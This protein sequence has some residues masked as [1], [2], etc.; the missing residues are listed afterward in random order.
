MRNSLERNVLD[1]LLVIYLI[2]YC[3]SLAFMMV[4]DCMSLSISVLRFKI[5][6]FDIYVEILKFFLIIFP[7]LSIYLLIFCFQIMACV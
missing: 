1:G 6:N 2:S 5:Y 7:Y 3:F 4:G